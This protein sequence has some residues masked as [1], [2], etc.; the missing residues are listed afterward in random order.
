MR[1]GPDRSIKEC[2]AHLIG[3]EQAL[4]CRRLIAKVEAID[5]FA[6]NIPTHILL[7]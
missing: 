1:Y 7:F 5:W 3:P 4:I 2:F 6:C